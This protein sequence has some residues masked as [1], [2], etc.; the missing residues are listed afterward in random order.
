MHDCVL[1]RRSS[2]TVFVAVLQVGCVV[3]C[4]IVY[5]IVCV[6]RCVVVYRIWLFHPGT[7][8]NT[9]TR[10]VWCRAIVSRRLDA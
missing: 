3:S 9:T 10:M 4:V 7:L 2:I 6:V 5:V 8:R 1:R